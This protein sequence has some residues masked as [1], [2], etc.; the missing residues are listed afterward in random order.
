MT[1]H[2]IL[3]I[4][5][6]D[7]DLPAQL[8]SLS[9]IQVFPCLKHLLQ[10]VDLLVNIKIVNC[11]QCDLENIYKYTDLFASECCPHLLPPTCSSQILS[12]LLPHSLLARQVIQLTHAC[13]LAVINLTY[14]MP[15]MEQKCEEEKTSLLAVTL[16]RL[17]LSGIITSSA[18][19][20]R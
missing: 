2:C 19:S 9:C 17:K 16:S 10:L 20:P 5:I 6:I 1:P 3:I 18:G 11:I 7:F 12:L 15:L 14:G 4:D 8:A 13:A